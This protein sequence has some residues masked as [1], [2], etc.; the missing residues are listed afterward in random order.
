MNCRFCGTLV[1]DPT[2]GCPRCGRPVGASTRDGSAQR[3]PVATIIYK[4]DEESA[5][6]LIP[7]AVPSKRSP[8]VFL[9]VVSVG[10]VLVTAMALTIFGRKEQLQQTPPVAQQQVPV[11][12]V[13]TAPDASQADAGAQATDTHPSPHSTM[14]T[15]TAV[16]SEDEAKRSTTADELVDRAHI[17]LAKGNLISPPNDNAV[18][19]S[20][21]AQ[22]AGRPSARGIQEQV[23]S[24]LM[25]QVTEYRDAGKN[26][27]A[28]DLI[29]QMIRV[30]PNHSALP[31]IRD[32]I[33]KEHS[34]V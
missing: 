24:N 16:P 29:E 20:R 22:R 14:M 26:A 4:K 18:Y 30:F 15:A 33:R 9:V 27:E 25:A 12:H 3:A 10:V 5:S 21:E 17:A 23:Y 34:G 1:N 31:A 28:L 13:P 32:A 8:V 6:N 19:W 11:S 2:A 7:S